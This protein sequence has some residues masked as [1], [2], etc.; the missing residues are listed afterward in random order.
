MATEAAPVPEKKKPAKPSFGDRV[1]LFKLKIFTFFRS[2]EFTLIPC[3]TAAIG[4]VILLSLGTWQLCRLSWKN[5]LIRDMQGNMNAPAEDLR[6]APPSSDEEWKSR[7]YHAVTLQG[8]WDWVHL[9]KVAPRTYEGAVGYHL[10]M[11]LRLENGRIVVVNRGFIPVGQAILPE[12][13]EKLVALQGIARFPETQAGLGSPEN[14]PARGQWAWPDLA[15]MRREIGVSSVAGVL[16]YQAKEA[17]R[18]AYPIGGVLPVPSHN[19]HRQYA[20]VWFAL[21]TALMG[22]WIMSSAPKPE[23][24]NKQDDTAA[25][26]D[27][28]LKDPV[29]RRG[30]YPEATD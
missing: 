1:L 6:L 11:P 3:A 26:D 30:E 12:S 4:V 17:A 14:D 5:D 7:E 19:R 29:A 28:R 18:D 22:V 24:A 21:A 27:E 16:F 9:F 8:V 20:F 2:R 15:A 10:Y 23:K 13:E 25:N